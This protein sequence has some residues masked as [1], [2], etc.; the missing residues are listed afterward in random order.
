MI[1]ILKISRFYILT[2]MYVDQISRYCLRYFVKYCRKRKRK[3]VNPHKKPAYD[4]F[5]SMWFADKFKKNIT[6]INFRR[7]FWF[8]C[9]MFAYRQQINAEDISKNIWTEIHGRICQYKKLNGLPYEI[10]FVLG[11]QIAMLYL[12]YCMTLNCG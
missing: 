11:H 9:L 12:I 8:Y 4:Q 2:Y 10:Y 3:V 1:D 5:L 7:L 6:M